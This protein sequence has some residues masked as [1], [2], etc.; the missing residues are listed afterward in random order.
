[1]INKR[2]ELLAPIALLLLSALAFVRLTAVPMFEDEGT[3]L[4]WIMQ[5]IQ[6]GA[7]LQPLFDG[8]PLE[9]WPVVPLVQMG[10]APLI[11]MRGL[12]VIAGMLG[13]LLIYKTARELTDRRGAFVTGLLFA[14]C[15][16][17]VYLQRLALSDVMLCAAGI[18]VMLS[19]LQFQKAA[20]MRR[21]AGLGA[22]LVLAA[23]CKLPVGFEMLAAMPA[24]IVLMPHAERQTILRRPGSERLLL[25]HV[26]VILLMLLVFGVALVRSRR[27]QAP[28]FGIQDFLGIGG[29]GYSN[30]AAALGVPRPQVLQEI[31]AQL[32]WP[33]TFIAMI[34]LAAAVLLGD[35]R[36]RWL[37][38]VGAMPLA[39][40]GLFA[41]F[42][43]PRY[44]LFTLPPLMI[45]SVLGWGGLLR[46]APRIARTAGIAAVTLCA[47]LMVR[48]SALLIWEPIAARWSPVDR[49]QYF[50]GWSSGYGYPE[51]A[52]F[53]V[54][55][56]A[57]PAVVY[58]LDGHSAY[59]LGVYLPGI[60][61]PRVRA[62]GYGQDGLALRSTQLRL[63][64]LL[65]GQ[66]AWIIISKQL[67][68]RYLEE[69]F[70]RAY[71]DQIKLSKVAEFDK[72]D[73]RTQL[74]IYEVAAAAPAADSKQ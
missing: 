53:I 65:S 14:L 44:L 15:P 24:A 50:S 7:W 16:Y 23:F 21:T 32:T 62:I 40:I 67:L 19:V 36:Q 27:G 9:A 64:S 73:S 49:I 6:K 31:A 42:W 13:T 56:S 29:G 39:A 1:M 70:G 58:S 63:A 28:G 8:K 71:S 41:S 18:W 72:P 43:Y 68:S 30:I 35:W 10:L 59:Q 37:V 66:P 52:R 45:A 4:R 17:V 12:H 20:T 61:R 60:W 25:A 38:A 47:G 46:L 26:P 3:Q 48:Q 54:N 2:R 11:A 5:I 69:T 51:A 55:A 34:G 33:V 74:A 22:S 57:A